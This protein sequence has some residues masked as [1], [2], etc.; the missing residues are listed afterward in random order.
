MPPVVVMSL[1]GLGTVL[2][3][4][5]FLMAGVATARAGWWAGWCR[6]TP[7]VVGIATV[8][9]LP[10]QFTALLALSVTLYSLTLIALGLAMVLEGQAATSTASR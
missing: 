8:V 2:N 4:V 5:G 10:L 3:A 6:F 7:L 1:F 9:L